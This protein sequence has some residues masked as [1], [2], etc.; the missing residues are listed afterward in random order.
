MAI[1]V[2]QTM[3]FGK[4]PYITV[5]PKHFSPDKVAFE[6]FAT[7]N[8]KMPEPGYVP[9]IAVFDAAGRPV[10]MIKKTLKNAVIVTAMF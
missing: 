4:N 2:W 9:N 10:K 8:Y 5:T 6:D 1:E 7:K 3:C